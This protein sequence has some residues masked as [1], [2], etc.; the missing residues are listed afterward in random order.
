MR[1][2]LHKSFKSIIFGQELGTN[3][4]ISFALRNRTT[5]F[6]MYFI[7]KIL[8]SL[9]LCNNFHENPLINKNVIVV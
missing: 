1:V 4:K 8:E 6:S 5:N 2:I 3:D 7:I 9:T